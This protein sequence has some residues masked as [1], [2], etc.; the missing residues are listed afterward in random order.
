MLALVIDDNDDYR[1]LIAE[2]LQLNGHNPISASDGKEAR[3]MLQ[4]QNVDLIIADVFMPH[5]DGVLFHSY[6]RDVLYRQDVPF[7][8]VS[9]HE[10]PYVMEG[11]QDPRRDYFVSKK[12]P[13]SEFMQTIN[14]A[15]ET[16]TAAAGYA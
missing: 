14:S 4:E 13:L 11:I 12:A 2:F 1:S 8:F 10:D 6:V 9:G 16:C 7:V 15:F 5:L 3:E